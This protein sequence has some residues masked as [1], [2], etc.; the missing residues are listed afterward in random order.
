MKKNWLS[1]CTGR[2]SRCAAQGLNNVFHSF[3]CCVGNVNENISYANDFLVIFRQSS[4]FSR[5]ASCKSVSATIRN[6]SGV[7]FVLKTMADL[8]MFNVSCKRIPHATTAITISSGGAYCSLHREE[9]IDLTECSL[10]FNKLL[11]IMTYPTVVFSI[12]AE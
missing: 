12:A 4:S 5:K 3:S 9:M 6:R 8:I 1:I 7:F 2:N 10:L 11:S